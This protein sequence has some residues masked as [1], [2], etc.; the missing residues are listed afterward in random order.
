MNEPFAVA[1]LVS[2]CRSSVVSV[3]PESGI[4]A[5]V[6]T[7]NGNGPGNLSLFSPWRLAEQ[8]QFATRSEADRCACV[9]GLA[10]GV[11]ARLRALQS[12]DVSKVRDD[13]SC[14][15]NATAS[16]LESTLDGMTYVLATFTNPEQ[17]SRSV[18]PL[19][20]LVD[21]GSTDC[22]LSGESIQKLRLKP[23]ETALFET[24]AGITTEAP[25]FRAKL[26]VLGR[27]ATV[28]L[29]PAEGE[30]SD[31]EDDDDDDDESGEEDFDA[32]FGFEKTS[33]GGLL[34]HDAL[35]ALGLAVD[36]RRRR[37]VVL[38]EDEDEGE[39]EQWHDAQEEEQHQAQEVD[40]QFLY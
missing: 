27:E 8:R 7:L 21:T 17:P 22:E 10:S 40:A 18:G 3:A 34:G 2:P 6:D 1:L 38:P 24:A 25:V 15:R 35:A 23:H 16:S 11:R 31:E 9:V 26:K 33:D 5:V 39:Q 28:L 4:S 32:R 36:C 37:L 12:C 20:V 13:A 30:S 29:S 19:R 14:S